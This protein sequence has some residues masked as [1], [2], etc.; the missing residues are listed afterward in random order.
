MDASSP[1]LAAPSHALN[2]QSVE[3]VRRG[4]TLVELLVVIGIIALLIAILLPSLNKAR[5]SANS[6]AC[7]SNLRQVGVAMAQYTND[8]DL[9]LPSWD[10]GDAGFGPKFWFKKLDR[11]LVSGPAPTWQVES[12]V[13]DCPVANEPGN[14]WRNLSYGYNT[15]L[16]YYTNS[17]VVITNRLKITAISNL[18][19]KIA[20]TDGQG[21]TAGGLLEYRSLVD[22]G[23][24]Y[25]AG[26]LPSDRHYGRTNILF[27][28][29]HVDERPRVE[30]V[31]Q[32]YMVWTDELSRL[33]RVDGIYR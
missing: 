4:F 17:G 7:K 22:S 16:G 8:N 15:L 28:D 30:I 12:K 32:A 19:G 2:A 26:Y 14:N 27:L 23:N 1:R 5:Q 18:T 29:G 21:V 9:F 31:T 6:L 25:S 33:W 11:Y 20:V 24:G 10:D 13:W 3:P